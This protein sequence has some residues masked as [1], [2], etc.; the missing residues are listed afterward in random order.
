MV[1]STT[2]KKKSEKKS[3]SFYQNQIVRKPRLKYDEQQKVRL[4]FKS[5]DSTMLLCKGLTSLAATGLQIDIDKYVK[6]HNCR[7]EGH[8]IQTRA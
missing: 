1:T 2:P 4:Y 5:G 8:F 7:L 6:R 3:M